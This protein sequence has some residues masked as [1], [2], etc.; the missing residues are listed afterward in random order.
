MTADPDIVIHAG[1]HKTGTTWL[2]DRIFAPKD[3][4]ELVYCGDIELIYRSFIT[5]AAGQSSALIHDAEPAR[6]IVER[7]ARELEE[8]LD[9]VQA[10]R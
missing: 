5:P 4:T 8:S 9:R 6:V 10:Q 3:G 1:L 2:Q 7:L